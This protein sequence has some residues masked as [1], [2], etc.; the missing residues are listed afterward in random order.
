MVVVAIDHCLC[1]VI[2]LTNPNRTS[3]PVCPWKQMNEQWKELQRTFHLEALFSSPKIYPHGSIIISFVFDCWASFPEY[4]L[5]FCPWYLFS[6]HLNFQ[7]MINRRSC[8]RMRW[9]SLSK[10]SRKCNTILW[11]TFIKPL[12]LKTTNHW[13]YFRWFIRVR[14]QTFE[15]VFC[16]RSIS[17]HAENFPAK[18]EI[19]S[20]S[21]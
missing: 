8:V 18:W 17:L 11:H 20:E 12:R 1:I 7:L 15:T 19:V 21:F 14:Q 5:R 13:I 2:I 4:V 3:C 16:D 9:P 10:R 6:Y